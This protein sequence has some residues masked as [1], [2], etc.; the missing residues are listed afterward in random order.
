M[1]EA[2]SLWEKQMDVNVT[3]PRTKGVSE[4]AVLSTNSLRKAASTT[5]NLMKSLWASPKPAKRLKSELN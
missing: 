5:P 1:S 4:K 3:T 2:K